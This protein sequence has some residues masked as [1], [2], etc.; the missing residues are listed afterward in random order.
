M[1]LGSALSGLQI[2]QQQLDTV[3]NNIANV[4]TT[5]YMRKILPQ[6]T[7]AIEGKS[8]GVM[9]DT[10]IRKV[11]FNLVRDIFTQVSTTSYL[12][13]K[14]RY[15]DQVQ[16]FHGSPDL[17]LSVA[18]EISNLKDSFASLSDN[19][20][21]GY[22]LRATLDQA[23][24][25]ADKINSFGDLLIQMRNDAQNDLGIAINRVND[26]LSQIADLNEQ[27]STNTNIGRTIGT[28][29]DKRDQAVKE[30][31]QEIDISFFIRGDNV[32]VV[33]TSNG[34]EIAGDTAENIYFSPRPLASTNYFGDGYTAG[35]YTR[36]DPD[37][38]PLAINITEQ[39]NGGNIGALLEMRDKTLPTFMAQLDELAHKM[40]LRFDSQG[41]RLFTDTGG[42]VPADTPPDYTEDPPD[43]VPYVGFSQSIQVNQLILEDYTL[44]RSGTI[45]HDSPVQTGSNEVIRRILDYTF[46]DVNYSHAQ[47]DLDM[48][49]D[50]TALG[51]ADYSMQEWL[52]VFSS[53]EVT[54]SR[55]LTSFADVNDLIASTGGALAA[56]VSETFRITFSDGRIGT[57]PPA[58]SFSI[59]ISMSNAQLQ[60]GANAAEQIVA[61]I[62]AGIAAAAG[63]YDATLGVPAASVGANGEIKLESRG[64]IDID[65]NSPANPMTA[66]GLSFLGL[67]EG[68]TETVDPYF[69]VQVGNHDPVRVYIEPGDDQSDLLGKLDYTGTGD[70]DG[71]V[72]G[73]GAY[74]DP[75]TGY[76]RVRPGDDADPAGNPLFGGDMKLF[77]GPYV[78]DGTGEINTVY[79][80]PPT[81]LPADVGIIQS[82]FGSFRDDGT[83]INSSPVTEVDYGSETWRD[84][85]GGVSSGKYVHFREVYLGPNA[86]L[87]TEILG[88]DSLIDFSQKMINR[89]TEQIVLDEARMED[90]ETFKEIL[91]S[92]LLDESGVNL[93]EEMSNMII[94]QNAYAAA[95][96]TV[97]A[98][99]RMFDELLNSI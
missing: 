77:G 37:D 44:L 50:R 93:D 57:P 98:V 40:A 60:A 24:D 1:S 95:A 67:T 91:E 83:I 33:Q 11:D 58:T 55:E 48:R 21:D 7:R 41:L 71:G 29:S 81:T 3:S 85:S 53:A 69:E 35:I 72:P 76:L 10:I 2:N 62:N 89:Q 86:D 79:P 19:P 36:G 45:N 5:G 12:D 34:V 15:L 66:A 14:I 38:E 78:T 52:G 70:T 13:T 26:L 42:D 87:K 30:L 39:I 8:V 17:E 84:T 82:L 90:E 27:I 97:Q 16:S 54:G 25:T 92:Q 9:A 22:A 31:A 64:N 23:I 32:M 4:G 47:G 43:P 74:I 49:S 94:I 18:A 6:S 59:D 88:S 75:A 96:R 56:G 63:T 61:E 80:G 68:T 46:S 65:A 28:L 51:G 73:L 20:E 99:N